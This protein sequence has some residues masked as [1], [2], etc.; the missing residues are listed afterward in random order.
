MPSCSV[1]CRSKEIPG[2][3]IHLAG[4]CCACAQVHLHSTIVIRAQYAIQY[5][6]LNASQ[7]PAPSSFAGLSDDTLKNFA[8]AQILY[9]ECLI[10]DARS[11]GETASLLLSSM[12]AAKY[13]CQLPPERSAADIDA[14]ASNMDGEAA[15]PNVGGNG[16]AGGL[17]VQCDACDIVLTF[18]AL[19]YRCVTCPDFTLCVPCHAKYEHCDSGHDFEVTS[20]RTPVPPRSLCVADAHLKN[21]LALQ[22]SLASVFSDVSLMRAKCCVAECYLLQRRYSECESIVRELLQV[23]NP[24][25]S[26]S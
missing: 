13:Q 25:R 1:S 17:P 23:Q 18:A 2:S 22:P 4:V 10:A 21:A 5:F 12:Q 7:G 19:C 14:S 16:D 15:P 26:S 6:P 11:N 8:H 9:A 3:I 20:T 24:R